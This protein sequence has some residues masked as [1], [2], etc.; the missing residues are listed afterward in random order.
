MAGGELDAVENTCTFAHKDTVL[1]IARLHEFNKTD[2]F[3]TT[4][5]LLPTTGSAEF[6]TFH[7]K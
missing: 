7:M 4:Y 5:V 3:F 2:I 6:Y 1:G